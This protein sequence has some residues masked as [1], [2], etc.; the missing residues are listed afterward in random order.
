MGERVMVTGGRDYPDKVA[1]WTELNRVHAARGVDVLI[2][3]MCPTGA[4]RHALT[5]ATTV[6]VPVAEFRP[7]WHD[8]HR[9]GA[10][11]RTRRDGTKYDA[12]AGP[13]RNQ[14]MVSEGLPTLVLAFPGGDGTADA[15]KRARA[16]GLEPE[17]VE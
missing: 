8:I 3:G 6:G 13:A 4:D 1:V 12:A 17:L 7:A 2:C 15:I 9:A 5:W 14:R 16:A 11:I 10:V